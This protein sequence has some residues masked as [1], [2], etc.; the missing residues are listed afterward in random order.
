[1][2]NNDLL[3]YVYMLKLTILNMHSHTL[4]ILVYVTAI[5]M[6]S[7]YIDNAKTPIVLSV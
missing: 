2:E 1:M 3:E 5:I 4:L 6:P 7:V